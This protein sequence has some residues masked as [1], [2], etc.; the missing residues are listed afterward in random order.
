MSGTVLLLATLC[1]TPMQGERAMLAHIRML[2]PG[3]LLPIADTRG[4]LTYRP[5]R[6]PLYEAVYY[7]A[8]RPYVGYRVR[9]PV[10]PSGSPGDDLL[11]HPCKS[12]G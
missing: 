11:I 10:P 9:G 8:D 2:D 5:F 4:N 6:P 3:V 7:F 1:V 12:I